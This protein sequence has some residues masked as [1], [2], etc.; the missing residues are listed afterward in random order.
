MKRLLA[1]L[2]TLLFLAAAAQE[3]DR[4]FYYF[5]DGRAVIQR[6]SL[7]GFIDRS[8]REVIPC[9]YDKAYNF[10][11]G[12]SMVRHGR[13]VFA[14]DTTGRR[15]DCKVRIPKFRGREFESFV[16]WV[17]RRIPIASTDE[18]RRLREGEVNVV[19]TIGPDGRIT[20]CEKA[21][22][23]SDEV[24]E[25]VRQ[26]V[27]SSPVW[28]PGEVDGLPCEIRYLLPVEFC[29]MRTPPFH[30][31]DGAGEPLDCDF[32]YP[33]FR[34]GWYYH[35][36]DWF[37]QN[38]HF[39]NALEYQRAAPGTVRAAFTIDPKGAV[40]DIE[41]LASHNDVCRD[42]VVEILKKSPRW[43]PATSCGQPVAVRC[44]WAFY[45]NFR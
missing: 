29:H 3:P 20:A 26:V 7:Y 38:L 4:W 9:Q 10:N 24:F 27:L 39:R 6:D 12:I 25:R 40:R 14:I 13:E 1:L 35:F 8:G 43:T 5:S 2:F 31:L 30:A 36:Y 15:L 37:F 18:F 34:G 33:L 22:D 21:D 32:V 23:S 28:T 16:Y 45:F 17:W 19:I 42:K 11:G 41:I 44:E